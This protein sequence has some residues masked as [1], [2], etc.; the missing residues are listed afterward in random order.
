MRHLAIAAAMTV[1]AMGAAQAAPTVLV[2]YEAAG[3][4]NSTAGFDFK[5]VETFNSRA[6]GNN[7]TFSS[8]FGT[9]GQSTVISGTYTGVDISAN[10]VYGGAGNTNFAVT[11]SGTGYSVLSLTETTSG[12]STGLNYFGYWLSALD[13]GNRVQL[14]SGGSVI[15]TFN[16]A[17]VIAAIGGCPNGANP[18]CGNPVSGPNQGGNT[19][20]PYVFVNFFVS[21][22]TFDAVRF[23][24][25][26][27]VG[28]Y[29]SD[30]HTVGFY[31]ATSGTPVGVP[32]PA[33]LGLLGASLLGLGALARRRRG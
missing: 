3:V 7:Q 13:S 19:A 33:T 9:T 11:F 24:E 20:E 28:G 12:G 27:Q 10:N 2:T 26:P 15:F 31:N 6:V 29:E 5:G 21:G 1:A 16:P 23:Y 30:N 8:D 18:Y 32:E 17:D 4:V 25:D 14:L 22:G